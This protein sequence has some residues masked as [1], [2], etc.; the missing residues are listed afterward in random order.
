M[1]TSNPEA[2]RFY[3][4]GLTKLRSFDSLTARD[5]LQKAIAVDPNFSLA[6]SA[7]ASAWSGLGYDAKAKEEGKK[8]FDLSSNLGPEER[9]WVEGQD[10]ETD[11]EWDKAVEVYRALFHSFPDNIDYGLRLANAQN[12]ADKPKDALSTV[13]SCAGTL[14]REWL[15]QDAAADCWRELLSTYGTA[16]AASDAGPSC[17]SLAA[18]Q[19]RLGKLGE[20]PGCWSCWS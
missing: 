15:D 19:R 1:L 18:R 20:A 6:H 3:S 13:K 4:E 2:A 10:R 7:L 16:S 17:H 12:S 9:L 8:A 14:W 11:K 5:L